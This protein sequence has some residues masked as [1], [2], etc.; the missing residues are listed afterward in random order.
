MKFAELA[1]VILMTFIVL[2]VLADSTGLNKRVAS[3][4][5][6]VTLPL[7][8]TRV[9]VENFIRSVFQTQSIYRITRDMNRY[10]DSFQREFPFPLPLRIAFHSFDKSNYS[11][12]TTDGTATFG[13]PVASVFSSS[14]FGIVYSC[15]NGFIK[16]QPL[17]SPGVRLP[18]IVEKNSTTAEGVVISERGRLL[19]ST[20]DPFY[21]EPGDLVRLSSTA[22]GYN[23]YRQM[24]LDLIGEI[25]GIQGK[26]YLVK[27]PAA[28]GS[29]FV[30]LGS[31]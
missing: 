2:I 8:K 5:D 22:I 16:V 4:F 15:E 29:Y 25:A 1:I 10:A 3:F 28:Y 14:I 6:P 18:A 12:M 24:K 31:H 13:T 11:I 19:F 7:L 27:I 17:I 9:E 30:F 26:D 23:Y 21:L 20:F